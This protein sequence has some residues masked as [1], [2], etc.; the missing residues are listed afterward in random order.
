MPDLYAQVAL[1]MPI[2]DHFDYQLPP[3]AV[4]LAVP[5]RWVLVPW[6]QGRRVGVIVDIVDTSAVAERTRP[7]IRVLD[8]VPLAPR[9]WLELAR[10]AAGYYHRSLGEV[11]VPTLPKLLRNGSVTGTRGSPFTRATRR[12]EVERRAAVQRGSER[13]GE[14]SGKSGGDSSGDSDGKR[15]N[16]VGDKKAAP[17]LTVEQQQALDT[18]SAERGFA[19]FLLHGITGSGK[20][21]VYLRWIEQLLDR[22]PTGQVLMLVPEIALTPQLSAQLKARLGRHPIAILH[23]D[24]ADGERAAAWLAAARGEARLVIGTR[25]S[26]LTPLPALTAIVVDEEHDASYKQQEGVHYS[27]RDLAIVL[28]AECKVPVVLGSATPSLESWGRAR[29]GRYRLLSLTERATGASLPSIRIQ[30][31]RGHPQE[32][33]LTSPARQAIAETLARSEQALV[34]INRRGYAP[35]LC[36]EA[37]GWLSACDAC[38]A[39]RVLHRSGASRAGTPSRYRLVCHHCALETTVPRTCPTCGNIDLQAL[40]RGTQRIEEGLAQ[41]FPQA[42][43][44][45]LDRDVARR[46]GAAEAV[47]DAARAGEVDLLVG[48]QMLAKGHDF[49]RLTLVVVVDAD[50]G[51]FSSDFRAPE[52]LFAT[53]TQVAG[54]A[55][56]AGGQARQGE[57]LIQ[58]R[59]PDHPLFEYLCRHDYA[60]FAD[61]QLEDRRGM[62]LP[63]FMYQALLRAEADAIADALGFLGQARDAAREIAASLGADVRLYDPVPMPIARI[64]GKERAQLLLESASR[65]A[66]QALLERWITPM[67]QSRSKVRWQIEVDPLEI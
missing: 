28:A 9:G 27:A 45:R 16:E 33:G 20:T 59:Y 52:R 4:S 11:L 31:L 18:L 30:P 23:S 2:G 40:G 22:D 64:A 15:G 44:A 32:Q 10:F 12:F 36:C 49:E 58:T 43:I 37:C 66:L 48:T 54:R 38:S 34:F 41:L 8:E 62:N 56:R 35:V 39:Y 47:I 67:R 25:L 29:A 42:R 51:L 26:V 55:G 61:Q 46:R 65:K 53:L 14:G 50:A 13:S 3:E 1:D 17:E 7:I 19:V 5:G 21:E 63:P 57:V 24:V 60:G 6:S